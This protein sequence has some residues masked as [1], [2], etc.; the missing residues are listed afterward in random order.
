MD[1]DD[2][3]TTALS[4]FYRLT[5]NE[6]LDRLKMMADKQNENNPV[7]RINIIDDGVIE[8]RMIVIGCDKAYFRRNVNGYVEL[9]RYGAQN[10]L[11][12]YNRESGI[13][14][15]LEESRKTIKKRSSK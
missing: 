5:G 10:F 4:T 2:N 8:F 13:K 1:P 11:L 14:A 3:G 6:D 15:A 7:Y 12:S 9:L